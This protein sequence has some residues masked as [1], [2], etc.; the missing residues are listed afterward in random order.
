[1]AINRNQRKRVMGRLKHSP[2]T[3]MEYRAKKEAEA[4]ER[5]HIIGPVQAPRLNKTYNDGAGILSGLHGTGKK[6]RNMG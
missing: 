5:M 2:I 3:Q 4:I 6:H 1:M